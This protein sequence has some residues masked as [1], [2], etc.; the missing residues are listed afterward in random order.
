[1]SENQ[2]SIL[3]VD[4]DLALR[5][6]LARQLR[7]AGYLVREAGDGAEAYEAILANCPDMLV[8]DW[9]M[10]AIDGPDLCRKV[11]LAPLPHYLY[12]LMLTAKSESN[13]LILGIEAGADDFLSKPVKPGELVARLHAGARVIMLEKSLRRLSECDSLTGVLNRRTFQTQMLRE[14]G[15]ASRHSLPLSCV[16]LD[17]DFFKK[18]NDE[19]GHA[20][21][22]AALV[23]VANLLRN[24]C[25]PTDYICRYGGEEFLVLLTQTD[26]NGAANWAERVR[27]AIAEQVITAPNGKS[28]RLTVSLGVAQKL[29][30]TANPERLIDLADQC[31]LVAKQSGRNRVVRFST[32]HDSLLDPFNQGHRH[33]LYGVLA[34]DVMS[35]LVLCLHQ[36]D[37]VQQAAEHVLQI[38]TGSVPVVDDDGHVVGIISEK[39][40]MA[41]AVEEGGWDHTLREVM[42]T[43]V[44]SYEENAPAKE[45][46]DF[47]CRVSIRRVLVVEHGR[48]VGVI[49]RE[50]FLRWFGNWMAAH[51]G[52]SDGLDEQATQRVGLTKIAEALADRSAELKSQLAAEH[53]EFI[54]Y[55]VGEATRMQELL[56]DLLGHCQ[57]ARL[58]V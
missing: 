51:N 34:R 6:L 52:P 53:D 8:T 37:R 54:P 55:V 50:S 27:E 57:Q 17:L 3:L 40:I 33:P 22:D 16:L 20:V 32:L 1:M 43:N 15:R 10:P 21:G 11:R 39:D 38:R 24:E 46:F 7:L 29:A 28:L 35:T 44:V 18:I 26:E 45:I 41:L 19:H 13:D 5:R 9:N 31:L 2:L 12:I 49:S 25:R 47:L 48:P 30:D 58:P 56:S 36:D 23:S 14:W 42:E 4:D